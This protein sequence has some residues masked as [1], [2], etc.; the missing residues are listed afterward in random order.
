MLR[1]NPDVQVSTQLWASVWLQR[2]A[3]CCKVQNQASRLK[4]TPRSQSSTHDCKRKKARMFSFLQH[5]ASPQINIWL[6]P[7]KERRDGSLENH[8]RRSWRF[9]SEA[10]SFEPRGSGARGLLVLAHECI[11]GGK[12]LNVDPGLTSP[13]LL[14][15]DSFMLMLLFDI[16][17]YSLQVS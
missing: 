8:L 10:T 13:C 5:R 11:R 14:R 4:H 9:A 17:Y 12:A 3:P 6:L 16:L 1:I 15:W 2:K 7:L